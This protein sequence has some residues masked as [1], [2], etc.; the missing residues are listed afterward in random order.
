[1]RMRRFFR[2]YNKGRFGLG[3]T[4]GVIIGAVV[5]AGGF[6]FFD[7]GEEPGPEPNI[8]TCENLPELPDDATKRVT[9][10]GLKLLT[11]FLRAEGA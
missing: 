3:L 1:M 8:E 2:K 10:G 7:W 11:P 9:K 4:L 6:Y 5:I